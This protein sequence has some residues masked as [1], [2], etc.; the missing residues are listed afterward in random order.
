MKQVNENTVRK[1]G[2]KQY[3][4]GNVITSYMNSVISAEVVLRPSQLATVRIHGGTLD[5]HVQTTN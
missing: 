5:L 1:S 4:Y 3:Q 2:D